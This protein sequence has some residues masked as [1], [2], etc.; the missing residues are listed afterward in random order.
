[1]CLELASASRIRSPPSVGKVPLVIRAPSFIILNSVVSCSPSSGALWDTVSLLGSWCSSERRFLISFGSFFA[2]AALNFSCQ[3]VPS[4]MLQ[5]TGAQVPSVLPL[6]YYFV[7][8]S[9][10]RCW[11]YR[12][13]MGK[14]LYG[15]ARIFK[16]KWTDCRFSIPLRHLA[17]SDRL[18]RGFQ[19]S[20]S[21]PSGDVMQF[22]S[23]VL[24]TIYSVST[25]ST[26]CLCLPWVGVASAI[27]ELYYHTLCNSPRFFHTGLWGVPTGS[28]GCGIWLFWGA[29]CGKLS[30]KGSKMR[31]FNCRRDAVL[32]H[33]FQRDKGIFNIYTLFSVV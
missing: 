8:A 17:P 18:P 4:M 7:G 5:T 21:G 13:H 11:D 23:R 27:W 24:R 1:M 31:D 20:S 14:S 12:K 6:I 16:N 29:G 25:P 33:F 26:L 32:N 9:Q 10:W 15:R 19:R 2:M 30:G 3:V 28:A 22:H